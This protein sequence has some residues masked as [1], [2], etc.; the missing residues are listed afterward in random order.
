MRRSAF[1][2]IHSVRLKT[3]DE[4]LIARVI[5]D[6]GEIGYGFSLRLDGTE[7]RHM[8]EWNAGVRAEIPESLKAPLPPEIEAAIGSIHWLP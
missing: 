4:I 8:A 1:V 7:A 5:S 6:S 3:G 2:H